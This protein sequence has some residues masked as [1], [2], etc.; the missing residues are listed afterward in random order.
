MSD[1][2]QKRSFKSG[3]HASMPR[4]AVHRYFV[5]AIRWDINHPGRSDP[6]ARDPDPIYF[7]IRAWRLKNIRCVAVPELKI[8]DVV[9]VGVGSEIVHR[10]QIGC[11]ESH[12]LAFALWDLPD[13]GQGNRSAYRAANIELPPTHLSS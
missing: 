4:P 3:V 10:Y 7:S 12:R 8:V 6:T 9:P 13:T 5:R 1:L 2:G 11:T